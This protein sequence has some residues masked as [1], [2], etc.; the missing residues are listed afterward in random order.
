[1]AVG[2][3]KTVSGSSGRSAKASG[4]FRLPGPGQVVSGTIGGR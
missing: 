1:M 3:T 2:E 4:G